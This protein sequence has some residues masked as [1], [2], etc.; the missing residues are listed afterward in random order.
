MKFP[1]CI[2]LMLLAFSTQACIWD[3]ETMFQEK[4]RSHDLAATILANPPAPENP[5]PLQERIQNL[6]ANRDENNPDWWNNLAGAYIRLGQPETAVKLLEPVVSKFPNNY[7]IHANLGTAYHLLGRYQDAEKEIARD[8]EINPDAH[9][10]LEKYHLAL[11]QYLVRDAKYQSRHVY[12]DELT[13]TFLVSDHGHFYFTDSNEKVFAEMAE[14]DF[15]NGVADAESFY[16][17]YSKTNQEKYLTAQVLGEITALDAHPTYRDKWNLATDT[18]FE[19]GVIYMA[20]MNPKEPA[21]FTML[22]IAAW[23][24]HNYHL[25]VSAFEKAIALGSPQSDLLKLKIGGLKEYI[26]KSPMLGEQTAGAIVFFLIVILIPVLVAYYFY[27]K[28]RDYKRKEKL[29]NEK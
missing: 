6:E 3:A 12:V 1:L 13:A 5:Q 27:A 8:L 16:E 15:T 17:S 19:A 20:E 18:N 11:L 10:R 25:A 4:M 28:Q 26:A 23:R 2:F 14:G 9:F 24:K 29:K 22:G 7:G 21:C